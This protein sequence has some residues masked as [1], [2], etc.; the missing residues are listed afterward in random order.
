MIVSRFAAALFFAGVVFGQTAALP[1]QVPPTSP[2]PA[3]DPKILEDGG[4]SIEPIYWLNQQQP[5]LFGGKQA[6]DY[7]NLPFFGKSKKAFGG[8]IGIPAGHANTLRFS[9]FRVQGNSNSILGRDEII[10][11]ESYAAGDYM[12]AS[13][14]IQSAKI[15]WDY[16]SYTFKNHVRFKTLYEVQWVTVSANMVAPFAPITTDSSGT[17]D[18]N[19]ATG[20]KN[21]VYPTLGGELEQRLAKNVRWEVKGSAFGLPHHALIWDTQADIALRVSSVELLVGG[22][23]YHFKTSPNSDQYFTDTIQGAFV[24]LRYYW[25]QQQN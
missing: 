2:P 22:R 11:S 7:A 24:G 1:V 17:T 12:A 5:S 16:L 13:Y 6:T 4:I 25:G 20:S 23:S 21:L 3:P 9:Y 18:N 10:F 14:R 8:E 15:S 19:T